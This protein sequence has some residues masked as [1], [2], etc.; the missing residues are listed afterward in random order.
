MVTPK[1]VAGLNEQKQKWI[2]GVNRE[3]WKHSKHLPICSKHFSGGCLTTQYSIPQLYLGYEHTVVEAK[4]FVYAISLLYTLGLV[5][6]KTAVLYLVHS[7][8]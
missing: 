2:N 5:N 7:F 1:Q 6:T 4:T 3:D 8:L